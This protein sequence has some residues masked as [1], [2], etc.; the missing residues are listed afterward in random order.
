MRQLPIIFLFA[1]CSTVAFS[2]SEVSLEVSTDSLN[3]KVYKIKVYPN[4][5]EYSFILETDID[6]ISKENVVLEIYDANGRLAKRQENINQ[7][8]N[9]I[10][11]GDL[12]GGFYSYLVKTE[13]IP[14]HT[15]KILIAPAK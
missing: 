4:P 7:P 14:V 15:G 8:I 6:L 12:P 11:R 3:Q 10:E 9:I 13:N 5:V 1:L 2:Q